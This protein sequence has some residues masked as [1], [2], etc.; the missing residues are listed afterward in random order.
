MSDSDTRKEMTTN[1]AEDVMEEN[2]AVILDI[3]DAGDKGAVAGLKLA[4]DGHVSL[5]SAAVND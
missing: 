3:E 4:K 2:G 1:H 5:T